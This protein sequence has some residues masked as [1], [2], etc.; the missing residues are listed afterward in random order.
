M[1]AKKINYTKLAQESYR[2]AQKFTAL[3][4]KRERLAAQYA[5]KKT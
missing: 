2:L 5:K 3:A 4:E 1:V